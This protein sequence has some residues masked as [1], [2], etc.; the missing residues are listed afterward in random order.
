M[1]TQSYNTVTAAQVEQAANASGV[2]N[3]IIAGV[4]KAGYVGD[5]NGLAQQLSY[6]FNASG[7]TDWTAALADFHAHS[8]QGSLKGND[9]SW[10]TSTLHGAETISHKLAG[11]MS[12]GKAL[13][14]AAIE[15][16]AFAG[17]AGGEVAGSAGAADAAAVDAATSGEV[18]AAEG[19]AG[20]AAGG[21]ASNLLKSG[22]SALKTAT[23]GAALL[24]LLA[25]PHTYIR[26]AELIGG[27]ALIFM[28]L[29]SLTGSTTTPVTVARNVA[30]V[31]A[32]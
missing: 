6:W 32:A 12:T 10:A 28:G 16:L 9:T 3:A 13:T 8:V 4:Y 19:A 5:V 11:A 1:A 24:A 25:D 26:L 29:R 30:K 18:A 31:A 21:G 15:T 22:T 23:T 14:L 7:G 27:I 17:A 20:G 2:P